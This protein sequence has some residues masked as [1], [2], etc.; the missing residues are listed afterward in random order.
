MGTVLEPPR[1]RGEE[2]R[3]CGRIWTA[4][5]LFSERVDFLC[6]TETRGLPRLCVR[7]GGSVRSEGG[8]NMV[9]VGPRLL[10]S[11]LWVCGGS[12]TVLV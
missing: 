5:A 10:R 7:H 9:Q 1:I 4:V 2:W 12:V 6:G 11:P 8:A 3:G